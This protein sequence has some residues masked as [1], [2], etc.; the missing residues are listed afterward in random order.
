MFIFLVKYETILFLVNYQ[1]IG[2]LIILVKKALTYEYC[3]LNS[4]VIKTSNMH[5]G[6]ARLTYLPS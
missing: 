6:I 1:I 2:E 5:L 4:Y 3:F